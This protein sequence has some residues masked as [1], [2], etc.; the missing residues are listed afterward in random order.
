MSHW[1]CVWL[2]LLLSSQWSVC[3]SFQEN[4]SVFPYK[5]TVRN[6]EARQTRLRAIIKKN[7][8]PLANY[9]LEE[10]AAI[11][12]LDE[13]TFDGLLRL[14]SGGFRLRDALSTA[15]KGQVITLTTL[16][17]ALDASTD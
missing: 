5:A 2:P 8:F 9:A 16:L 7:K 17:R 4:A 10:C 15:D 11:G 13:A 3:D 1:L 14:N 6:W 12:K